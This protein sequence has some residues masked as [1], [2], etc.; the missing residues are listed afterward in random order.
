MTAGNPS[1][2]ATPAFRHDDGVTRRLLIP[3]NAFGYLKKT[4]DK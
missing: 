2:G 1:L 3:E 4:E